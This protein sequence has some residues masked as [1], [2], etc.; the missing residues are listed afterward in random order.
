MALNG[1]GRGVFC[2]LGVRVGMPGV[3]ATE[4]MLALPGV[5]KFEVSSISPSSA[6]KLCSAA[7]GLR[8]LL[9]VAGESW[10]RPSE[11]RFVGVVS[12]GTLDCRAK[13]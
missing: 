10:D 6:N 7:G 13:A 2:L 1:V 5:P 8:S 11:Y 4:A 3:D 12:D 9:M